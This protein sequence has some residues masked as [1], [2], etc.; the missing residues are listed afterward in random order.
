M[1]GKKSNIT[2]P[3]ISVIIPTKNGAATI[4]ECLKGIFKQ[5]LKDIIEVIVIDSGSNDG[6]LEI[7]NKFPVRL[8]QIQPKDF[9]HGATRNY[10]VSLAWGKFIVMTVQDAI[11]TDNQWIERMFQHFKNNDVAAVAGQQIVPHHKNKNPHAWYRPVS[12]SKATKYAFPNKNDFSNLTPKE[13]RSYCGLDDVNAMYR[14]ST[15]IEIPF[16][17][18]A[19][20]EDMLWAHDAFMKGHAIVFD[21]NSKVEHYHYESYKYTY[22]LTVTDLYFQF[23]FFGYLKEYHLSMYDFLIII[24]RNFK[25]KASLHWIVHNWMIKIG[26]YKGY[27]DIKKAIK[28]NRLDDFFNHEMKNIPLGRQ[29]HSKITPHE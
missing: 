15:L 18:L 19:Y 13:K 9:N 23:I 29:K 11:A 12:Q 20:G 16:R 24:F 1:T 2:H 17:K 25:Y 7:T 6:T 4:Y 3:I 8:Y 5:T 14:K 10:G 22:K 28:N 26:K 27:S 21:K